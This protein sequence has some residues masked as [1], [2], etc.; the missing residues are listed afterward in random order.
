MADAAGVGVAAAAGGLAFVN[1]T[2]TRPDEV[3]GEAVLLR[4][5]RIGERDGRVPAEDFS[6]PGTAD[7]PPCTP[8]VTTEAGDLEVDNEV[9]MN[10]LVPAVWFEV[11]APPLMQPERIAA[12]TPTTPNHRRRRRREYRISMSPGLDPSLSS[13]IVAGRTT[14]TSNAHHRDH[15]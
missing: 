14:T 1:V 15:Q 6:G 5:E 9:G 3:V 11:A 12:H 13:S 2:A 10:E 7:S 8:A 4:S